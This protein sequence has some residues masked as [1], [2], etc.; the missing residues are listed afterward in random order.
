[1][2]SFR[3]QFLGCKVSY[4]DAQDVRERL[5]HDGHDEVADGAELAI[6]NTCCVT[7]EAVRKSRQSVARAARTHRRVYVTGCAANL[8]TNAFDGIAHNVVVV[9][10]RSELTPG[11][12]SADVG[13]LG[14]VRD[15]ARVDRIRAF[16]K[17]QDGCS[18]SCAFC[19]VPLVRGESRSR[20]S[21]AVLDE[22]WRR[23]AQGHRE[24]VLTGINLGCY[25]D[26]ESGFTLARLIREAGAIPGLARLRISSIE[27]N[28]LSDELMAAIWETP[29]VSRHLH[30]PL[31]SG[32]DTVLR[33][34]KRRYSAQTYLRRVEAAVGFNL[35]TDVI[36]G[37]PDEDE[38]AFRN[39]LGV[40][41]EAGITK[42][43][44]FPYSPRPGTETANEDPVPPQVKKE[45]S[46]RLREASRR[47]SLEHWR[48]KVGREDEVLI[49]RPGRGYG[50]DYSPWLVD[51]PVGELVR[52][53]GCAVTEEGILAAST[54]RDR[55]RL[56]ARSG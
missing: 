2:A 20:R 38:R 29:N 25:R 12:V 37:F 34:M 26:R 36:V 54:P 13:A 27:V 33:S 50:D 32:D 18:F 31:Q 22:I 7:R 10:E 55:A 43:H 21:A 56:N 14:C 44:V 24:V 5:L 39:T 1:M 53:R 16:V 42:C 17:V 46:A 35:T 28:H 52:V 11:A 19:V 48:T 15:D 45:R 41:E 3:V 4:S 49:D 23:V 47:A 9:R 30:V 8:A 40:V 6:V 51:G